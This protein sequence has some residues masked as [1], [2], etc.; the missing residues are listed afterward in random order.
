[1]RRFSSPDRR[2]LT[3]RLGYL[4]KDGLLGGVHL[5]LVDTYRRARIGQQPS[6]HS[7]GQFRPVAFYCN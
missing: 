4:N 7:S 6:Q 1:M 2:R 5:S 3:I